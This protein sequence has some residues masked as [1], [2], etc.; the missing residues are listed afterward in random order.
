M[1]MY[2]CGCHVYEMRIICVYVL[3]WHEH[4]LLISGNVDD[5]CVYVG[6][7]YL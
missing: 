5:M 6:Y 3:V 2:L 4:I 1:R 7:M